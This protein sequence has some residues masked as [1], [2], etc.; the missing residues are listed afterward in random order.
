[1]CATVCPSEALWYGTRAEF[2]ERRTGQLLADWKFGTEHVSTKVATVVDDR[3]P[4][5]LDVLL[6]REAEFRWQ[7]D[8][9]GLEGHG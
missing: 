6:G 5:P 9:F 4:G 3:E 7:D 2:E 1:M 8:P